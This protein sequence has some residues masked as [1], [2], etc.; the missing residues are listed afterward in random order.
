MTQHKEIRKAAFPKVMAKF[1]G[2]FL[3]LGT[4]GLT[5]LQALF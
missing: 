1:I 4:A 3:L 2:L 5:S